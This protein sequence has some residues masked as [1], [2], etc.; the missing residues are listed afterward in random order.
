MSAISEP[1]AA[2]PI[3]M[4][5]NERRRMSLDW[6]GV[7]PFII[8]AVLFLI[9]PTIYLVAGA[10]QDNEGN[11]TL[12]NIA[13]LFQPSIMDAYWISIKISLAS[14]LLGAFIGFCIAAAITLGGLPGWIRSPLM[15]FSGVASNFAG[16]PL[17]FAF[18]ATLG[19]TGL[20]TSFLFNVFGFNLYA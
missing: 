5:A 13:N 4:P 7:M 14:A 15:T 6:L 18:L 16:V 17:A 3:P 8:F 10:F 1:E 12:A 20:V 19:R 2:P 9:W 11:L